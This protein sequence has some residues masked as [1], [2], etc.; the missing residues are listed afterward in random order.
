ISAGYAAAVTTRMGLNRI[1]DNLYTLRRYPFPTK[2]SALDNLF[3][4]SGIRNA[5]ILS[6]LFPANV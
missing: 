1:G 3:A 4:I 2:A 6:R 5:P